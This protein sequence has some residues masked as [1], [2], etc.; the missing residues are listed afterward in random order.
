MKG[1]GL[2]MRAIIEEGD[3]EISGRMQELALAE[4]ALP[5]HLLTALFTRDDNRRMLVHRQLSR[6]LVGLW[7]TNN[8]IAMD[9]LARLMVKL[10]LLWYSKH[11]SPNVFIIFLFLFSHQ[12]Y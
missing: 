1:A 12:V 3:A 11:I 5:S 7:V 9:L 6:H 2:V 10:K 8:T 4:A